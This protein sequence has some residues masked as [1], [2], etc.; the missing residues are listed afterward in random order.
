MLTD[1]E[2]KGEMLTDVEDKDEV[3]LCSCFT[4][5]VNI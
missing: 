4:S 2:V 1:V 5:T 3:L